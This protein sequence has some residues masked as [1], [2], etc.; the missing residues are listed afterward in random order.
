MPSI[1]NILA[2]RR[3]RALTQETFS[4]RQLLARGQ[5]DGDK[6]LD[7]VGK[8]YRAIGGSG[9]GYVDGAPSDLPAHV[10]RQMQAVGLYLAYTN[11]FARMV[12]NTFVDYTVGGGMYLSS[13]SDRVQALLDAFWEHPHNNMDVRLLQIAREL[14]IFGEVLHSVGFGDRGLMFLHN[15]S[16]LYIQRVAP[17]AIDLSHMVE[18][19][20][21]PE[22]VMDGKKTLT[23][24]TIDAAGLLTA[25]GLHLTMNGVSDTTRGISDLLPIGDLVDEMERTQFNNLQRE[26]HLGDF[27]W[28][29]TYDG[30]NETQIRAEE[31]R[32]R[33]EPVYPGMVRMHNSRVTWQMLS[34]KAESSSGEAI[35]AAFNE[36]ITG[37]QIPK[38]WTAYGDATGTGAEAANDPAFRRMTTRQRSIGGL[39]MAII[40]LQLDHAVRIKELPYKDRRNYTLHMRPVAVR[41]LQRMGGAADKLASSIR[42]SYL[43]GFVA[44]EAAGEYIS[45]IYENVFL[46]S[47]RM[48]PSFVRNRRRKATRELLLKMD[49]KRKEGMEKDDDDDKDDQTDDDQ[50]DDDQSDD[51][52]DDKG[53]NGKAGGDEA[54]GG[55]TSSRLARSRRRGRGRSVTG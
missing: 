24:P 12:V 50:R 30:S 18:V 41:D 44:A 6:R 15:I 36:F 39:I 9:Y 7:V 48:E 3:N 8:G 4:T 26:N 28:D 16:P 2:D 37:A 27:F 54:G 23:L 13:D 33:Q 25:D 34:P 46:A 14:A 55:G 52:A 38:H 11:P 31:A 17:A 29:V 45:E 5:G 35:Q 21:I 42:D 1:D 32:L 20:L 40:N 19:D 10:R 43:K 47:G 51:D 53:G 49:E 22:L